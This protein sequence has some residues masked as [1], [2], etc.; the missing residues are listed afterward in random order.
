MKRRKYKYP[1]GYV[2][3]EQDLKKLVAQFRLG[4]PEKWKE[5]VRILKKS[6]ESI[7]AKAAL[8]Q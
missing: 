8:N 4:K 1:V 5:F 7:K 6:D 3:P 2:E